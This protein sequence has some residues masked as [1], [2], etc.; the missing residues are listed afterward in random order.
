MH[1]IF[2][3]L[4]VAGLAAGP[5]AA[6]DEKADVMVPVHQFV[7]GFNKGNTKTAAA[8]SADQ[9]SIIDEFPPPRVARHGGLLELGE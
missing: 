7:D 1:K 4:A 9:T 8:A 2:I 6:F 3:A 5:T